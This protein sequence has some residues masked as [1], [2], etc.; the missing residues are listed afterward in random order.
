M[1]LHLNNK[2]VAGNDDS[3]IILYSI[4]VEIIEHSVHSFGFLQIFIK[5]KYY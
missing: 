1:A 5:Y 4:G 3:I 2:P